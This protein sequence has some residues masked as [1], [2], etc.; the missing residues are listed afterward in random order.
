MNLIQSWPAFGLIV[1]MVTVLYVFWPSKLLKKNEYVLFFFISLSTYW[2]IMLLCHIFLGGF[3]HETDTT[4]I[5]L[6]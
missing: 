3:Q 1:A 2:F 5:F 4:S 6:Q